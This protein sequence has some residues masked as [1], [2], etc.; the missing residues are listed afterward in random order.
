MKLKIFTIFDSA[1]SAFKQPFFMHNNGIAIRAF[2]DLVNSDDQNVEIAKHPEQFTLFHIGEYDDSTGSIVPL[3]TPISVST[4]VELIE[5]TKPKY[6]NI[7]MQT[8]LDAI[9]Q[10]E[11]NGKLSTELKMVK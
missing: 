11:T 9:K 4:G 7:D 8:I 5:D 1:A 3:D 2:S 10:L 6:T